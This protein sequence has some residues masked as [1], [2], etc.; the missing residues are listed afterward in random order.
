[1]QGTTYCEL[2]PGC[3]GNTPLGAP[4]G[5]AVTVRTTTAPPPA[6]VPEPAP[7]LEPEREGSQDA[8]R[9]GLMVAGL[10]ALLAGG[11][12][13]DLAPGEGLVRWKT[14]LG[15]RGDRIRTIP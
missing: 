11:T 2:V 10:A 14:T 6:P 7:E 8:S 5:G 13:A 4:C 9:G 3:T 1:I 12:V 15:I